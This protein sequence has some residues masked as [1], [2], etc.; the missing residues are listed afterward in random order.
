MTLVVAFHC[1]IAGYLRRLVER[2]LAF[3]CPVVALLSNDGVHL[4]EWGGF[5]VSATARLFCCFAIPT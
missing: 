2:R 3:P 5:N 4:I 1:L